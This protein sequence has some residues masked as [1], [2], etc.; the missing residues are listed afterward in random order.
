M[1]IVVT[2]LTKMDIQECWLHFV[3]ATETG[4]S[5][6]LFRRSVLLS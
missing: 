1:Q 5:Q 4:E 2:S 6:V 3:F